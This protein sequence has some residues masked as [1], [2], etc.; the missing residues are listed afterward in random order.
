MVYRY[1]FFLMFFFGSWRCWFV[2]FERMF[3]LILWCSQLPYPRW[4]PL[5]R[6]TVSPPY[7]AERDHQGESIG[8]LFQCWQEDFEHLKMLELK[9]VGCHL[10]SPYSH[11]YGLFMAV[12]WNVLPWLCPTYVFF[13]PLGQHHLIW[14]VT[15]VSPA[16]S[17]P[18]NEPD[19]SGGLLQ[20]S[21]RKQG[22]IK[23]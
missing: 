1:L 11:E 12:L 22:K 2:H 16:E 6:W 20:I 13:S 15:N 21:F 9:S 10:W 4:R 17:A 8:H 7:P 23:P 14:L 18:S 3:V 5:G 19:K